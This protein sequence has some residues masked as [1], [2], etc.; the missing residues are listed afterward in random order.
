MVILRR[1]GP[2]GVVAGLAILLGTG[3]PAAAQDAASPSVSTKTID[4]NLHRVLR[5]VINQGADLFNQGD[6]RGCYY[7]YRGALI[8]ARSQLGHHSSVQKLIDE[9]LSRTNAE[10]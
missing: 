8:T 10:N 6:Q 2:A 7:L 3:L 9:G 1:V 5:D 4:Q